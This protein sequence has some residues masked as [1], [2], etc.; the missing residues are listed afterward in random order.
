MK[1]RTIKQDTYEKGK[2]QPREEVQKSQSSLLAATE[3]HL[4]FEQN[5]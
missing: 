1:G 4:N 3:K 2:Q 5:S